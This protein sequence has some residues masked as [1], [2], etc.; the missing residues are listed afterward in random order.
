[1]RGCFGG[2]LLLY[3]HCVAIL[4]IFGWPNYS[5]EPVCASHVLQVILLTLRFLL[6][7]TVSFRFVLMP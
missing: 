1:M 3:A 5:A 6:H 7:I 4:V 2:A